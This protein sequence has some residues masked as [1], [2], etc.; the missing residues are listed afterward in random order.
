ME[1]SQG[2]GAMA[3]SP[4]SSSSARIAQH[5]ADARLAAERGDWNDVA[6]LASTI[7][8]LDATHPEG[9][10]LQGLVANAQRRPQAAIEH[11][12]QVL[13]VAPQR[14]DAAIEL[15]ALLPLFGQHGQAAELIARYEAQLDNSPR[16]LDAAATTYLRLGLPDRAWPLLCQ[17][18]A[19]QP[20]IERFAARKAECA[21][22]VGQLDTA[23]SLYRDLLQRFPLH[24]RYHYQLSRLRTAKDD[25]HIGQMQA[26]LAQGGMP[27][28]RNI[29]LYY[30]LGKELEDR[31]RWSEAFAYYEKAGAAA[32]ASSGY[33]VDAD[34][35]LIDAVI[36]GCS[37]Q[38]LAEPHADV[39]TTTQ[40]IFVT[41]LPR[42]G[43]TLVE[44]ILSSHSQLESAG[45][46]F[47]M[48]LALQTELKLQRAID[49]AS[50]QQALQLSP[51][52]IA[53]RY[54]SSVQYRLHGKPWFID[55]LPE[56]YLYLGFIARAFPQAK[57]I[58][59][60][61]H[62]LDACFALFKQSYFRYAYRLDDLARYYVAYDRLMKH[63]R[64][65][66]GDRLVE[67]HYEDLSLQP[68]T[69]IDT[70]LDTLGLSREA[71]CH[72]FHENVSA[73]NTAS[74][75]QVREPMH[76]RSVG[77][78]QHFAAELEPLSRALKDAG[79]LV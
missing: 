29:F 72:A 33:T 23:E 35:A 14:Y 42:T 31:E 36:A 30:A 7:V 75:I 58:H 68:D 37:A 55:K 5:A 39:Q 18:H 44:R 52:A 60:R 38:W 19:L 70:L 25:A 34:I 9:H 79:I 54:R 62:P 65:V 26:V 78:W 69:T 48:Q 17:A 51:A 24:Q 16:Y 63:W 73:T 4:G 57:L 2:K 77:K 40:P 11:F 1:L 45:E 64:K 13:R 46:T 76:Q 3:E 8:Q 47:F 67:V 32:V 43:T 6:R 53:Q 12:Q 66:L 71:A 27:D 50:I 10:F 61:R 59:L 41:G 22:F 49:A 20:G 28:E 74:A 15:A 21:V 56:N